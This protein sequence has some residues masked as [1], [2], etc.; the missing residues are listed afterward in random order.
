MRTIV[1]LTSV[2]VF[3]LVGVAPI[4][5]A[6]SASV[7]PARR[8][9]SPRPVGVYAGVEPGEAVPPPAYRRVVRRQQRRRAQ[10]LTWPGFSPL[11]DGSSRFFVQTTE[12]VTAEI[13]L[14][15]GRVVV[16]FPRTS[17]HLTNS[18]RWLETRYFN[19]PVVRARLE[20]RRGG[21]MALVMVLRAGLSVTPRVTSEVAPGG[22]FH[23]TYIDFQPGD[24]APVVNPPSNAS[25]RPAQG[26]GNRQPPPA[27]ARAVDP[28]L[29]AMDDEAPPR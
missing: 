15:A 10:I 8:D 18:R 26:E 21:A 27:P 20:R 14:E 24:Y 11:G 4:A 7:T 17:I 6:Q 5:S 13:R 1:R 22:T 9:P 3:A 19:T 28:S 12:P 23:Y 2:F 16:L 29:N 25:V